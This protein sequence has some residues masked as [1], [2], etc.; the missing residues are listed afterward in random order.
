M[1]LLNPLKSSQSSPTTEPPNLDPI[2]ELCSQTEGLEIAKAKKK[3][4]ADKVVRL[5]VLDLK[6]TIK[7]AKPPK[8]VQFKPFNPG[9]HRDLKINIPSNIDAT[10]P[11][12]LLD[13]FIPPEMY[14]L[15]R[16]RYTF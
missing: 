15:D 5:A 14:P 2:Q 9:D 7:E 13:L 3:A 4:K 10:N 8:E 12:A 16:C 1:P 6:S 11:L